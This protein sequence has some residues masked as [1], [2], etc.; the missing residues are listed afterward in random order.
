MPSSRSSAALA[1]AGSH[2][3]W[4][5]SVLLFFGLLEVSPT[6]SIVIL[7]MLMVLGAFGL[8]LSKV[9]NLGPPNLGVHLILGIGALVFLSQLFLLIGLPP[10]TA[11]WS[12]IGVLGIFSATVGISSSTVKVDSSFLSASHIF[13]VVSV[14][15]VALSFRFPWALPF[16]LTVAAVERFIARQSPAPKVKLLMIALLALIAGHQ[17]AIFLRSERWWY[18]YLTGRESYFESIAWTT[19]FFGITEHPGLSGGSVAGYHWLS[20]AFLGSISVLGSLEPWEALTKIGLPIVQFGLASLLIT[21]PRDNRKSSF[22]TFAWIITLLVVV[23]TGQVTY[24]SAYFGLFAVLCLLTITLNLSTRPNITFAQLLV[25]FFVSVIAVMS[26]TPAAIAI[27]AVLGLALVISRQPSR[28]RSLVLLLPLILAGIT[29]YIVFFRNAA[30]STASL[31]GAPNKFSTVVWIAINDVPYL[32]WMCVL[33]IAFLVLS[34]GEGLGSSTPFRVLLVCSLLCWLLFGGVS[35][36]VNYGYQLAG[37]SFFLVGALAAWA[38]QASLN[39]ES[40]LSLSSQ[41]KLV[42]ALT[43]ALGGGIGFVYPV[44]VNRADSALGMS[45]L[46]GSNAWEFVG[47][48]LIFAIPFLIVVVVLRYASNNRIF[49]VLLSLTLC[50]GLAAGMQLDR[51]RRVATW[52]PDVAVN[53]ALNDSALPNDD[54]RAVG[55]YV[56]RNTQPDVVIA[57]NDF[58]C[59]GNQWWRDI[60]NNQEQHREKTLRWWSSLEKTQWWKNLEE[61]YGAERLTRSLSDNLWGGDNYLVAAE[62]RRRVLIEGLKWIVMTGLPTAD[63]VDRMTLSLDFANEPSSDVVEQLKRY[64][65]SGYI[66]N[67]NL[68][69]RRSWSEFA[70]EIYRSGDFVYLALR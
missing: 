36:F 12:A 20:Y 52:G 62:T 39:N 19:S 50:L 40:R 48:H 10:N 9:V 11:Q 49:Y 5:I 47:D 17:F 59:F 56:R 44:L 26:K 37:P 67:L 33:L 16:A 18:F 4:G 65:V 69:S 51:G 43:L 70:D 3:L 6:S 68:T 24:D 30:Y 25:I 28:T 46:L 42:V 8:Q 29:C 54:L 38:I 64:G 31:S 63:H 45:A 22:S 53:W 13:T 14:A 34:R 66:V 2:L 58:C 1:A 27:G 60:A 15:I 57:T 32:G 55:T 23:G 61:Q 41:H 21:V 35:S 7:A